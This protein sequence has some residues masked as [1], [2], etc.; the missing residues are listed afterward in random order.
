[1]KTGRMPLM[2]SLMMVHKRGQHCIVFV[3]NREAD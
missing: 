2:K 1:M 3:R